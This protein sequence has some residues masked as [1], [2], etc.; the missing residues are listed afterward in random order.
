MQN[1]E[2]NL[3]KIIAIIPAR[4]GSKRVPGKNIKEFAGKPIIGWTIEM[5][6]KSQYFKD[7]IVSTDSEEIKKV[8]EKFGADVPFIRPKHLS[9]DY[10]NTHEVIK[11]ALNWYIENRGTPSLVL[12]VYP[13]AVLVTPEKI[14][15]ALEILHSSE[16]NNLI[17]A[18]KY[19]YPIERALLQN[20]NNESEMLF[21][22]HANTRMQDCRS[23]YYDAGQF[24]FFEPKKILS[25]EPFLNN[26][27]MMILSPNDAVDIDTEE[28][29][30]KANKI[31]NSTKGAHLKL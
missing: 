21:K 24:Y 5:L 7:I 26:A 18:F 6:K 8:S 25:D 9:D 10:T 30:I 1:K 20:I 22:E 15:K 12:T 2:E 31:F 16:S 4:A 29:F 3:K 11:H 13:T 17:T 28:D 19:N 23:A 27:S 14:T